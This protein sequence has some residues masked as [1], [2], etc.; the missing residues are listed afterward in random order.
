MNN[1]KNDHPLYW[2]PLRFFEMN[3]TNASTFTQKLAMM[4]C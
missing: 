4:S 2:N 3:N 1:L